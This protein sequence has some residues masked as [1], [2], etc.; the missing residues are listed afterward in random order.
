MARPSWLILFHTMPA[1]PVAARMK[2]WRRLQKAGAL[3]LKGTV[4]LLPHSPEHH[5]LLTWLT[6]EIET[7]GG[8]ADFVAVERTATLGTPELVASFQQARAQ[9]YDALQPETEALGRSLARPGEAVDKGTLKKLASRLRRLE[10]QHRELREVDFFNAAEGTALGRRLAALHEKLL[11]L[12][13]RGPAPAGPPARRAVPRQRRQDY[14]GRAWVT[15]A[16]PFVDRMA[17]AWLIRRFIDPQ[18][19]F[20]FIGQGQPLPPQAV[21]F[22]LPGGQFSHLGDW[23]TFE[24]LLKAFG[25]KDRSL[26]NL[27]RVVHEVDLRDGKFNVPQARGLEDILRGVSRT[28][29]NDQEALERGMAVFELLHA[30]F[31]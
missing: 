8:Q 19:S 20:A 2:I 18:A 27:A 28:A 14:Q 15:R 7:L 24:V 9:A 4:Y 25:L 31:I 26:A 23:C 5:E 16:G 22:D 30:S 29:P 13:A 11:S 21:G 6:Q 1:K 3:H 12:R 17:S 10:E